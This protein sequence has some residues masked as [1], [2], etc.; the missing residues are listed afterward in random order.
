MWKGHMQ[1]FKTLCKAFN[2]HKTSSMHP[3]TQDS[4]KPPSDLAMSNETR[5]LGVNISLSGDEL[6]ALVIEKAQMSHT[7]NYSCQPTTPEGTKELKYELII[8]GNYVFLQDHSTSF[9][10]HHR[11]RL[12]PSGRAG[13][14]GN[15]FITHN[16]S[17]NFR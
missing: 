4:F 12:G 3:F 17:I 2:P 1:R 16:R 11:R 7:G 14:E 5:E 9:P 8:T 6:Y 13:S 10:R 15:F